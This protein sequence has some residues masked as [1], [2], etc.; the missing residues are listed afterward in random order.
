[1][2]NL[3]RRL[4]QWLWPKAKAETGVVIRIGRSLHWIGY[5]VAGLLFILLLAV[6]IGNPPDRHN[7]VIEGILVFVIGPAVVGRAARYILANE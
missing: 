1:M 3:D 4:P 6:T 2:S 5:G 7:K